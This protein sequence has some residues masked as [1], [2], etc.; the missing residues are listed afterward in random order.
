MKRNM[1]IGLSTPCNEKFTNFSSTEIGGFCT[2]CQKEVIDF[3]QFTDKELV[4]YLSTATSKT[5]GRFK[6]SQLRTYKYKT[7][8]M[9][10]TLVSKSI[11]IMGFSLLALCTN[12]ISAQEPAITNPQTEIT[13]NV[14]NNTGKVSTVQEQYLVI[15]TIIDESNEPLPGV[16]VILKGTTVGTQTDFDGKFEFPDQLEVDDVLVFSFLG[17]ETQEYTIKKSKTSTIDIQLKFDTY[18]VEL[19]GEVVIDGTYTSKKN[20]FQKF[21]AIFK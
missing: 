3:T 12:K 6:P 1:T 11:G 18:D 13:A 10:N 8:P 16:N 19:M 21:I 14:V 17:Y 4:R 20:I 15:G 2:S 9:N 7:L 5:C